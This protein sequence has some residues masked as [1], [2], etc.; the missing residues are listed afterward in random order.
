MAFSFL[1]SHDHRQ[2]YKTVNVNNSYNW[3]YLA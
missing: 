3:I 1:R 2:A